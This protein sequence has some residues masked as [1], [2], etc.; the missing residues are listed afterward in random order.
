MAQH[1]SPVL[2]FLLVVIAVSLCLM[3][4]YGTRPDPPRPMAPAPSPAPVRTRILELQEKPLDIRVWGNLLAW[5]DVTLSAEQAGKVVWKKPGLE[6]GSVIHEGEPLLKLDPVPFELA[7]RRAEASVKSANAALESQQATVLG[8]RRALHSARQQETLADRE[9]QRATQLE[10]RG[11]TSASVL[12]LAEK[13]RVVAVA[14]RESAEYALAAAEGSL[15][16]SSAQREEAS[17]ALATAFDA[18]Q[19]S[20]LHVPFDG[21]LG[22]LFVDIGDW[23]GPGV[24]ALQVVDRSRLRA[25][26]QVPTDDVLGIQ[27]GDSVHIQATFGPE[28]EG[29]VLGINPTV[30]RESRSQSV[31]VEVPNANQRFSVGT[32]VE[33][34]LRKGTHQALWLSPSDYS[35]MKSVPGAWVLSGSPA[36]VQAAPLRLGR[37][38]V[39][40]DGLTWLPVQSGLT[41][42]QRIAIS[43]LEVLT[44]GAPVQPLQD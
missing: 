7:V 44:E 29:V 42:G 31:V 2:S 26:L 38:L 23:L 4:I 9:L 36:T 39:D 5:Q 19:R 40:R 34:T 35:L 30:Q 21:E 8:A 41:A 3:A 6:T 37:P 32:H 22:T 20:T 1:R 43:N 15:R 33:A 12:D 24:P 28:V 25:N 13:G 11:D 18:L 10:R 14:A 17:A 16:V 27:V